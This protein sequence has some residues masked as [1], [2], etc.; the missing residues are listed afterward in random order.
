[1]AQFADPLI[2]VLDLFGK[3]AESATAVK[4]IVGLITAAMVAQFA[5]QTASKIVQLRLNA[6][7]YK[8]NIKN[9][10]ATIIEA[11]ATGAKSIAGIPGIG[12][13]L[14]LGVGAAIFGG[15]MSYLSKSKQANDMV[16][17]GAMSGGGYGSRTLMGPEGA[18]SL[19]NKDTVIAGTNLFPKQ[20][21]ST[22]QP[23]MQQD[24]SEARKTNELL[25]AVLSQPKPQPIITMNDVQLGTAVD[26]GAF[27]IQ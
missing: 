25:R 8:S 19:N 16:M 23:V 10:G 20:N 26:M 11:A 13:F 21:T 9:A 27:S 6:Q 7:L 1:M 24:N 15:L 3:V 14:A 2:G 18:I 12:G 4:V 22:P 5:L 17:P